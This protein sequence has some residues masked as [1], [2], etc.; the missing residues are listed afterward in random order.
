MTF[1]P[2][3]K[4]YYLHYFSFFVILVDS[5][6]MLFGTQ[7]LILKNTFYFNFF[8]AFFFLLYIFYFTRVTKSTRLGT[9]TTNTSPALCAFSDDLINNNAPSARIRALIGCNL[10]RLHC[11]WTKRKSRLTVL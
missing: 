1:K 4:K 8:K 3:N 6:T 9:L 11:D 10:F 7:Y 5:W 2:L